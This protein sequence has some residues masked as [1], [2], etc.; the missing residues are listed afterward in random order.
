MALPP[1]PRNLRRGSAPPA[2]RDPPHIGGAGDLIR[3]IS[4]ILFS[5][6]FCISVVIPLAAGPSETD[7]ETRGGGVCFKTGRG[8]SSA[9]WVAEKET[10]TPP[11]TFRPSGTPSRRQRTQPSC[12]AVCL[13]LS[14]PEQPREGQEGTGRARSALPGASRG[15]HG[16][17]GGRRRRGGALQYP[18]G[19]GPASP[20][21]AHPGV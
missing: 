6:N 14:L 16:R 10:S 4:S 2:T 7:A 18:A 9:G 21:P 12:R 17:A 13:W 1:R 15:N 3:F 19:R 5:C 20:A 11:R 8:R